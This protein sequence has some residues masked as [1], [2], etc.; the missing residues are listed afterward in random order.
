MIECVPSHARQRLRGGLSNNPT[1]DL[2]VKPAAS[3]GIRSVLVANRGEIAI[4]VMRA[5]NELGLRTVA[6]YSQEDRFSLHRT[7]ADEAYLVGA[8]K[9]P[10]EAYLD[11]EGILAIA[12]EAQVD[13]L[14]PGYGFLSEN[15]QFAHA[16]LAAGLIFVGPG[17]DTLRLLGNK[18]AARE[19][20]LSAGV[21]V[22]PATPALPHELPECA[23]LAAAIGYPLML[24]ASWGGGGRG[25]RVVQ[26]EAQLRE[27]LP[28]CRR[29]AQAAF[30]NDEVYLEKL[31]RRA[32]HVEVQILGDA[33]G[34]LVHLF[35]RD[36]TVQRR[37]QKVVERAPAVFLS[38]AQREQLCAMA[39]ALAR[40][41]HYV[42]AGTVEFLQDADC[43]ECYFIEVNPRI[44][45]EHTVT[46][47]VTGI[48]LV[49]AQIRIA[50]GARIGD[51]ASGVPAQA[52]IQV[53]G[54]ALQCRITTEDPENNFI[55]DYG[56]IAAY[57]SPA[58][59]GIRLDAGTAYTGA[60]IT[61]SYDSL[62]VK[63]TAWAP[64]A[65][66]T[67]ARM[68]RALWEF[69]IRGVVSNLRFL[70]Q[71]ITHP[72]FARGEYSTRFIEETPELL[73]WPRKRDRATR[74]LSFIGS[75][76]V[77]GNAQVQGRARPERC[78]A[79][80]LPRAA[81]GAAV[82]GTKQKLDELGPERFARWML[83]QQRVLLT[84]TSMRDAHQSL[85]A[86][87]VRTLDLAAIAPYYASLVPQLFSLECWGGA[88]FDVAM[89][90]LREDPW[91]RLRLLRE[92]IPNL[93][94]QMLLRGANAVGYT[95]Y[96]DNVV[97]FFVTRAAAAGVDL[98]RIFDSL[99]WVENM[100][101]AIDAV[102]ESGKLC[103]AAICYTG[104]LSD[105]QQRKYTLDYYL[106]VA[107]ELKAA[108]THV[109]GV[110]DM[111]GLAR[112]RATYA[113]V[114]ALKEEIGLPV[115]F[116]THDTSGIAGA[117]VLAAI[118][119]GADAVDGAID[120][121]SGLTSQ[122]N[123]GAIVEALRFGPRDPGIDPDRLR[124]ISAYFEQV[125]RHYAAFE[126]D[127]R[128]GASEVY[129]HGMPGGQY[130]NLREQARGLGIEPARWPEVAAA[131]AEVN[132]MFGDIVKV[133][134]TSKVVGDM[135]LL[136][137]TA[138]LTR[139]QVLDPGT[140]VAF[141]ES[142]VQLF[143]GELGQPHGG[144]PPVLQRKILKGAAP[145]SARP[146]AALPAV[147]LEAERA[148]IQQLLPR[149]VT[150]EDL[151]SYLMYPKVWL[152]YARE[153]ALYGEPGILPTPVF[154][155]GM[156]PGE[157]I[158][159]DLERGKTLIVR[160]LALSEPHEDGTRTVFFEL[161]GQ[162]R[163]VRVPDKS[164][165]ATRPPPRKVEPGN[166]R[167]VGAPMPGVVAT[168]KAVAGARVARGELLVTLEAMKMETAVRAESDGE[169][170]EVLAR[171][172][173]TVDVKDLLVVLR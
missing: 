47:E 111:A 114:R 137:V 11:I 165:V 80:K 60:I 98:F 3:Q 22:M 50:G 55:P 133:T 6:I 109:L 78:A 64:S 108:G 110:K 143:R 33:H 25:T 7:K 172:G 77:N 117:S 67:I 34:T 2:K 49:K 31:V 99:N 123:L 164:R 121:M 118:E 37:H 145:L 142:V 116:H 79:A 148:R 127:I 45:V 144:F 102:L 24:K 135:A 21:P 154:F 81:P 112:P 107:R 96:P 66:E 19:L 62:L 125:R 48:D 139:E 1:A 28:V 152:E 73:Q 89:R 129:V 51:P 14:H 46:E 91:Q 39:L 30:G 150:D 56:K 63:V 76:I 173:L 61:R 146:G 10:V 119:A 88:T 160:Y 149:P 8:G 65:E 100:R 68:H 71:L 134:P 140:E 17:P 82:P 168:V 5:A 158:S 166:P 53:T 151:A 93:L 70:D 120:A 90:F 87:R 156:E 132:D 23:R 105:P 157:E 126:S 141:P 57:R 40:A 122:P 138:G 170:A 106:G 32:R 130:T 36:C 124:M 74:I 85:L 128:A 72:R 26:D 35:E 58:G 136:M 95:N 104:N 20:A 153:R 42:N 97:R 43:G 147:D 52:A 92:R 101:V 171:P 9:G 44:Q 29:E 113:L 13:A 162:P 86:T 131:Y 59:F 115:H 169:I 41:A 54:H 167:H 4:R 163:S 18:V 155:Y 84:D 15:P 27:L 69:R 83:E 12:R 38:A 103:E 159:V 75:T 161:N 16:C 94:L